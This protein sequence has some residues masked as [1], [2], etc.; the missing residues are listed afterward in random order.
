EKIAFSLQPGEISEQIGTP[1]G[2]VVLKCLERIPPAKD[3]SIEKERDSLVKE[4]TEKKIQELIPNVMKQ[5]T[6]EAKPN[7]LLKGSISEKELTEFTEREMKGSQS[8]KKNAS[9]TEPHGN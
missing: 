8:N 7:L 2:I 3:K 5:L 1:Q 4:I 9:A 6:D